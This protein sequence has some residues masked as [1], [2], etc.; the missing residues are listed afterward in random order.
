MHAGAHHEEKLQLK[1][2]YGPYKFFA[3][4]DNTAKQQ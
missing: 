4:T 2:K 1:I 3:L